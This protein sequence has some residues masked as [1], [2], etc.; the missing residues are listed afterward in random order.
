MLAGAYAFGLGPAVSQP[1]SARL[2]SQPS[3]NLVDAIWFLEDPTGM[4]SIDNIRSEGAREAFRRWDPALGDLNF[5]FSSSAWWIR[6]RLVRGADSPERWILDIP[7]AFNKLIDFY[8][9]EGP[10]VLTGHARP[11]VNRPLLG[12]HF[13][14]P[15]W[16]S[17]EPRDYLFRVASHYAVT[18]PL[19]AWQPDAYTRHALSGLV[20][21]ALY[22]G[23]LLAMVVYAV[24]VGLALRDLRFGLFALYGSTLSLAMLAG[25][26][27]GGVLVW[28]D[29]PAFDEMASAA[30][31][32]FTVA[33]LLLFVM[34]V[35]GAKRKRP[36]A[37][38][39]SAGFLPWARSQRQ[40]RALRC[41]QRSDRTPP[42]RYSFEAWWSQGSARSSWSRLPHGARATLHG[43]EGGSSWQAGWWSRRAP[44]WPPCG[45]W[46]GCPRTC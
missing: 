21:Q 14:F 20:L 11:L 34:R 31:L 37:R 28:P 1:A 35:A 7:Y 17:D 29:R 33:A 44:C 42:P 16:L 6:V 43:R 27:W 5:S 26:G 3:E 12:P 36:R 19:V 40:F 2:L 10:A 30:F 8:P 22:H 41:W 39:A 23:A 38:A 32:C 4:L 24:L 25:N 18:L 13:A 15:V 45:C 9:P 46:V